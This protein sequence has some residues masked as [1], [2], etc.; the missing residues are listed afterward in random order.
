MAVNTA[1]SS[2][3]KAP[4]STE[5]ALLT[6][7]AIGPRASSA[8]LTCR[9]TASASVTSAMAHPAASPA[10]TASRSGASLRPATVTLAPAA[11]SA[12]ATARPMPRP[13]P[14]TKACLPSSPM[15]PS[16][17]VI[18]SP[19][20]TGGPIECQYFKPKVSNLQACQPRYFKPKINLANGAARRTLRKRAA[21]RLAR[22]GWRG[23]AAATEG[24]HE[25]S[26]HRRRPG[27]P[28]FRELDEEGM[29]ADANHRIR[30]QSAGRHLRLRRGLLGRDARHLRELRPRELPRHHRP[31]RLL[32]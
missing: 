28:L 7:I 18:F 17:R 30:A 22:A 15:A 11:A 25:N 14:V 31:F 20:A 12:A 29:A 21:K 19:P 24:A 8:A 1:G 26:H 27:R 32:G 6:R 9:L 23:A 5:P 10:A 3:A 16:F 13:P 2:L 4:L